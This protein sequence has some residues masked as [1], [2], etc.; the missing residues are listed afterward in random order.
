MHHNPNKARILNTNFGGK[1]LIF[2]EVHVTTLSPSLGGGEGERLNCVY[3]ISTTKTMLNA[4]SGDD[5]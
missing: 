2:V 4:V 5:W 3:N 1:Y